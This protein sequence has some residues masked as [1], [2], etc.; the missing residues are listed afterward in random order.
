MAVASAFADA[1]ASAFADAAAAAFAKGCSF[2][3]CKGRDFRLSKGRSFRLS[4]GLQ[5]SPFQRPQPSPLQRPQ[6]PPLQRPQ[7]PPDSRSAVRASPSHEQSLLSP[8]KARA[9][10]SAFAMLPPLQRP[11]PDPPYERRQ[12]RRGPAAGVP[13]RRPLPVTRVFGGCCGCEHWGRCCRRRLGALTGR[14]VFGRLA[15]GQAQPAERLF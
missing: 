1:A 2:R 13:A 11:T 15:G 9:A 8:K 10:A 12:A 4:K 5:L 6:P 7:L 14:A 3:P